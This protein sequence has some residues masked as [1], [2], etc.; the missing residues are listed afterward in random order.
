MTEIK[1]YQGNQ[2][3]GCIT[4]ISTDSSKIIIDF[5]ES[6]P[7]AEKVENIDY[8]WQKEKVDAV[9]FT[10]YHGDHIGRFME[11]PEDIHL[12]MG[13]VT[14]NVLH[15]LAEALKQEDVITKLKTRKNLHF[16]KIN[17]S[18]KIGN[19]L[20]TPY[21]VDHS[22]FDAYMFLV[23]TPDKNILHTGDYREHGHRGHIIKNGKDVN[24]MLE[25][26]KH[27]V[28]NNGKR[29]ID[30]LITEGTML[31]RRRKD[32]RY[33]EKQMLKEATELFKKN[34]YVFLKI[35]STNA[36]S[37]ATFYHAAKNNGMGFYANEY[38]KKQLETFSK[39]GKK[40]TNFYDFKNVYPVLF[41]NT[42]K[43]VSE[44]YIKSYTAQRKFMRENGFVVLVSEYESYEKIM[45][46]FS[47]LNPIF[48]YS[49]WHGYI[50]K[51]VK[52]SYNEKLAEFCKKHNAIEMHTSGHAYP[53]FIKQVIDTVNAKEVKLIHSEVNGENLMENI[54]LNKKV[55]EH[56]AKLMEDNRHDW[57]TRYKEYLEQ[58]VKKEKIMN[59]VK[60]RLHIENPLTLYSS[61]SDVKKISATSVRYDVR[62]WGH[63]IGNIVISLKKYKKD[64]QE[65]LNKD[66]FSQAD[67][68]KLNEL[69]DKNG[70]PQF[71][72]KVKNSKGKYCTNYNAFQL[73][74]DYLKE[75]AKL[76]KNIEESEFYKL[77]EWIKNNLKNKGASVTL[78]W[79]SKEMTKLRSIFQDAY[80]H[81]AIEIKAEHSCEN[82]L[83]R[84]LAET[85]GEK[86]YIKNIQPIK[87]ADCAFFQMPTCLKAS[88]AKKIKNIDD[89]KKIEYSAYSGGGIDILAKIKKGNKSELCVIELKDEYKPDERPI[90][91]IRQAISYA[92][93]L[94]YILRSE[95]NTSKQNWYQILTGSKR[96][97]P[98]NI[99]INVVV[100]MPFKNDPETFL[101]KENEDEVE[102]EDKALAKTK[103]LEINVF[104]HEDTLTLHYMFFKKEALKKDNV[105]KGIIASFDKKSQN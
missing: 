90:I 34:K 10:H 60:H 101:S 98:D 68:R 67:I 87:L 27:H 94:D 2:I 85:V 62:V 63:S 88:T 38:I 40:Y 12:Y 103:P 54:D 45:E 61:I 47:D 16:I 44:K 80:S 3:G 41:T 65:I 5:G 14:W 28:K 71:I 92:V 29:K 43:N 36:D 73:L 70:E 13:E 46:E 24:I 95:I 30:T 23:E 9:F 59:N 74:T 84:R 32:K 96:E 22:A 57:E 81:E 33:S 48:I 64:L 83:L 53:E 8:N 6:L 76:Y 21:S 89:V 82:L 56:V 52:G 72:I 4:E 97:I 31:G 75:K 17:E 50:D 69:I 15:N 51:N 37:L 1:I 18:V 102:V 100:A 11:I 79:N 104:G 77:K 25:V 93:C 99:N 39:F 35:S 58:V 105:P 86:K 49:M 55:A 26:I 19:I 66:T 7:G 91:A 20:A 78:S 42:S